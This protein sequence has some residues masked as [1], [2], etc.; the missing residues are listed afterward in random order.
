MRELLVAVAEQ[1]Q[2]HLLVSFGW[3]FTPMITRA[4]TPHRVSAQISPALWTSIPPFKLKV[5]GVGG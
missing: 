4:R 1:T 2:R 5:T 3:N